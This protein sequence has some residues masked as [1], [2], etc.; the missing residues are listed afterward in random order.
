MR[1]SWFGVT[2]RQIKPESL[3]P[4]VGLCKPVPAGSRSLLSIVMLFYSH[5]AATCKRACCIIQESIF[6][7]CGFLSVSFSLTRRLPNAKLG[8]T[9]HNEVPQLP[10]NRRACNARQERVT[11]L[12]RDTLVCHCDASQ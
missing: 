3:L 9:E 2:L 10:K 1:V 5:L 6:I 7:E 4:I 8:M 12:L 11:L